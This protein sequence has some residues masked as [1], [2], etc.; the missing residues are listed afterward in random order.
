MSAGPQDQIPTTGSGSAVMQAID[1]VL[2]PLAK[3]ALAQG[4]S[5]Q[6]LQESLKQAV[7]Q[8]A[9]AQDPHEKSNRRVSQLSV[10]TGINRP[11]IKRLLQQSDSKTR[12]PQ[13]KASEVFARWIT[14]DEYRAP[15]GSLKALPRQGPKPSFESL[16]SEVTRDVHPR[17]MLDELLRLGLIEFDLATDEIRLTRTAFVPSGD[18]SSMISILADNVGDHLTAAV[19]N[20]L[21]GGNRHF[22]QAVFADGL[23]DSSITQIQQAIGPLWQRVL[24]STIPQLQALVTKDEANPAEASHRV[25]I[26]LYFYNDGSGSAPEQITPQPGIPRRL[27]KRR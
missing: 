13:S 22:E 14:S 10:I 27:S 19:E 16:V 17:S 15:S 9:L 24:D 7:L 1:A 5:Y 21:A 25:R 6:N 8:A 2:A 26:G 4:V 23:T 3:L 11:E 18:Q 20:L 12:Q